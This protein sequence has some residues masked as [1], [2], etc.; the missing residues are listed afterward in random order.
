M[1]PQVGQG[2]GTRSDNQV[3]WANGN[4]DPI[5][6]PGIPHLNIGAMM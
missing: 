5:Q 4:I 2:S 1:P 6:D 3:R